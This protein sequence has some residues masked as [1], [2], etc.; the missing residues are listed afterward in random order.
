[1]GSD[2]KDNLGKNKGVSGVHGVEI[3]IDL[4]QDSRV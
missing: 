1:M 3:T 2:L 4:R